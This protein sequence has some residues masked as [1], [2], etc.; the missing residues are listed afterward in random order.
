MPDG[1]TV[2]MAMIGAPH[3]VR[4]AVKLT[5]FA[6]DPL[7]LRRYNPFETPD[8]KRLKLT[9]VKAIGKGI[10]VTLD[11]IGD[12]TAAEALR[13]VELS[14]PRSRLPRPDEDEFYHVDLIGLAA[15]LPDGTLLGKVTAVSDYGAGD[16]L[17]IVGD[18]TVLVP[19]T[20]AIV[21]DVD[22][23]AGTLT[24]DPPPGLLDDEPESEETPSPRAQSSTSDS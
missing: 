7:G 10:V 3:G 16:I 4:G 13:G 15:H 5:V 9:S 19:F 2:V 17:E 11:G 1:K 8:G 21:P 24:V 18:S 12:R 22:L 20:L 23:A 6:D 14:I